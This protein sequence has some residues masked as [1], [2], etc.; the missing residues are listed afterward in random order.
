MRDCIFSRL[1]DAREYR[2]RPSSAYGQAQ[3]GRDISKRKDKNPLVALWVAEMGFGRNGGGPFCISTQVRLRSFVLLTSSSLAAHHTPI[4]SFI[5]PLPILPLFILSTS[6]SLHLAAALYYAQLAFWLDISDLQRAVDHRRG[7]G[8]GASEVGLCLEQPL[9]QQ[10]QSNIWVF[11][12]LRH[13]PN[14]GAGLIVQTRQHCRDRELKDE[15]SLCLRPSHILVLQV[16][17]RNLIYPYSEHWWS[18]H[19]TKGGCGGCQELVVG[20]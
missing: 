16:G 10:R 2:L 17:Q 14:A 6:L 9:S 15:T 13:G 11:L 7:Y 19:A 18:F 8:K 4:S 3:Y 12:L 1:C 5:F 20:S